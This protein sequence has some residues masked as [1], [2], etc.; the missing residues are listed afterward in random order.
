MQTRLFQNQDQDFIFC[1]Q[2]ASAPSFDLKNCVM[3]F[4]K[5]RLTCPTAK[6]FSYITARMLLW[7]IQ[8][9][10]WSADRKLQSHNRYGDAAILNAA[11]NAKIAR[12]RYGNLAHT[13]DGCRQQLSADRDMAIIDSPRHRSI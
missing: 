4:V 2:G 9:N 10:A 5:L 12:I 7:R 11:I 6:K 1:P 8:S 13:G 3:W